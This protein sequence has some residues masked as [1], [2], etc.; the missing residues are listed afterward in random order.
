MDRSLTNLSIDTIINGLSAD[1]K[2]KMFKRLHMEL[3]GGV[4]RLRDPDYVIFRFRYTDRLLLP[5]VLNRIY[6][7][8]GNY[9]VTTDDLQILTL[10]CPSAGG[11]KSFHQRLNPHYRTYIQHPE[12]GEVLRAIN[13]HPNTSSLWKWCSDVCLVKI[14]DPSGSSSSV[15]IQNFEEII[16]GIGHCG[17][18]GGPPYEIE[19]FEITTEFI[20]GVKE[21]K[22]VQ[23]RG[24]D[25][26]SG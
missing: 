19:E 6:N 13:A 10:S 23:Y 17:G 4:T 24:Y 3:H 7:Q 9:G 2:E 18:L 1:V 5:G 16:S 26:E 15:L 21:T 8:L 14:V 12:A 25:T 11:T 20:P 22:I